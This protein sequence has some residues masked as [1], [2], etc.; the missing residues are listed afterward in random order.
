MARRVVAPYGLNPQ[1]LTAIMPRFV[2]LRHEL[3]AGQARPSHWDLMF[4]NGGTLRTWTV[5]CEPKLPLDAE[6]QS[7]ADHRIEYLDY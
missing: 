6:A 1:S 5:Q 3:P 2:I 4:E 7:L